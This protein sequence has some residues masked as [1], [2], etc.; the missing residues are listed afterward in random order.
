MIPPFSFHMDFRTTDKNNS[1]IKR[2][3]VLK[4]HFNFNFF[5]F[6]LNIYMFTQS[7]KKV[8]INIRKMRL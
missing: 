5:N 7:T 8:S 3:K 2:R 1:T 6:K 4:C